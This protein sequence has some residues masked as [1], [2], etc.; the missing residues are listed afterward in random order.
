MANLT[1]LNHTLS[2][3][4]DTVEMP[5]FPSLMEDLKVD[6]CIVGGG[7]AGLTSAYL[8]SKKGKKVCLIEDQR[9]G[10]G[11]SG[12]TTA[13]FTAALDD[14]YFEIERIF[15]EEHAKLAAESHL[16]AIRKVEEIIKLEK[17]DCDL[18][19]VSG[20]LFKST[21]SPQDVLFRESQAIH[22]IKS[23]KAYIAPRAP[24]ESFDTGLCI[25]FPNQL[26]LHP[27][28]Y[29][30]GLAQAIVKMGG[31]IFE[32]TH[33]VE[34]TDRDGVHVVTGD[35]RTVFA[36]DIIVATNTPI[37]NLFA[38]HTKQSAYRTY[39]IGALIPKLSVTKALYWDTEDP[40]HYVRVYSYSAEHDILIVGG[41]DHKTGQDQHPEVRFN[42]LIEWTRRRFPVSG[43]IP[44]RWSGQVMEP[45]D[46]LGFM[47]RNP[48]GNGHTYMITGDSG[49]GMTHTTIGAMLVTDQIFEVPNRWE[50][51]YDPG[52]I[53][54]RSGTEY[55]KQNAN[56]AFQYSEWL[57]LFPSNELNKMKPDSGKVVNKGLKKVAVYKNQEG[58][59][60]F[61]SAACPHLSGVVQWNPVEKSWDCPC[62]GSRFDCHGKVIEG[63]AINNL[64]YVDPTMFS[65]PNQKERKI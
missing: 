45:V 57:E 51:I 16:A 34:V 42:R 55:I 56:V 1:H 38:I 30:R 43:E 49:N 18:E 44:Y 26:Q 27:M 37:N 28:K 52:R 46:C 19:R 6:V 58:Q 39:V 40:Y 8:L 7:I 21:K 14:R 31:R 36:K 13:H 53:S 35:N 62:H 4:S 65:L 11:Q 41:E 64:S 10:G 3:W 25:T 20:Y 15:G 61:M 32:S 59:L 48:T 50:V 2:L 29:M 33:A 60:E 22:K 47:G 17:I 24:I 23:L 9:I 5:N 63:P 54:F 12:Q